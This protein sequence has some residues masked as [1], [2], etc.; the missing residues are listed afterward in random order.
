MGVR[1]GRFAAKPAAIPR[2]QRERPS[3]VSAALAITH[4]MPVTIHLLNPGFS[5]RHS[6][7]E[8]ARARSMPARSR[9]CI[10]RAGVSRV[11][12]DRAD[13]HPRKA[14]ALDRLGA[15][16]VRPCVEHGSSVA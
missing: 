12:V 11:R 14:R 16:P 9:T 3:N 2:R 4:G 8:H 7:A 5:P 15:G 6:S 1:P 13:H 10:P